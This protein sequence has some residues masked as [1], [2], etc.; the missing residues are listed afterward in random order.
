MERGI[1]HLKLRNLITVWGTL[2]S[3][4]WKKI[5]QNRVLA[6]ILLERGLEYYYINEK[7]MQ[8][9]LPALKPFNR[10]VGLDFYA[11]GWRNRNVSQLTITR[12]QI[13]SFSEKKQQQINDVSSIVVLNSNNRELFL[14]QSKFESVRISEIQ[15]NLL[16]FSHSHSI[17]SVVL[18]WLKFSEF[19]LILRDLL[20][21]DECWIPLSQTRKCISNISECRSK[22]M[23]FC[24]RK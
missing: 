5:G 7:C 17:F 21:Q 3:P 9:R 24:V 8:M 10:I 6:N 12:K 2:S 11:K 19:P 16:N 13:V 1:W 4:L 22:Q 23:K 15:W 20:I 14:I 18:Y